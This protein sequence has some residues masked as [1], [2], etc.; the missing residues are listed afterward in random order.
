[1]PYSEQPWRFVQVLV[2]SAAKII[3]RRWL[4]SPADGGILTE[5]GAGAASD[6]SKE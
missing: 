2:G 6:A 1:M 5:G 3:C 4:E